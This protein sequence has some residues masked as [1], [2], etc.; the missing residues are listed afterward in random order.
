MYF[1]AVLCGNISLKATHPWP[2]SFQRSR[3]RAY[4]LTPC[5]FSY[6]IEFSSLFLVRCFNNYA[7]YS[8]KEE[9]NNKYTKVTRKKFQIITL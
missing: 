4:M 6:L 2:N 3:A 5:G 7:S 9:R 8:A 1:Y